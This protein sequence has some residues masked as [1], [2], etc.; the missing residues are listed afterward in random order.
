MIVGRAGLG[1]VGDNVVIEVQKNGAHIERTYE[2]GEEKVVFLPITKDVDTLIVLKDVT[3]LVNI[4]RLNGL[5]VSSNV[6]SVVT[7]VDSW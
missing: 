5:K 3:M 2:R 4:G 7:L 6:A 1:N